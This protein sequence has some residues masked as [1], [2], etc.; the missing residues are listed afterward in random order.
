M[1]VSAVNAPEE[2][3]ASPIEFVYCGHNLEF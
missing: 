2:C 1:L 3:L